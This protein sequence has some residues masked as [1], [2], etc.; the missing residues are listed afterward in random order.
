[1][2][3]LVSSNLVRFLYFE[4]LDVPKLM[5][6]LKETGK[7]SVSKQFEEILSGF[8]DEEQTIETIKKIYDDKNYLMDTHTAV[9]EFVSEKVKTKRPVIVASTASP[10]KFPKAIWE[11]IGD[12]SSASDFELIEKISQKTGVAVPE[13]LQNLDEKKELHAKNIDKSEIKNE[14]YEIVA[15]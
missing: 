3:I 1:M 8:A 10:Y 2:D 4:G 9:A 13:G 6:D 5:N 11:A 7:F 12:G 15:S 14:V